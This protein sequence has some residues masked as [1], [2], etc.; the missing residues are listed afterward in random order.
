[1][2]ERR[3][4]WAS[5]FLMKLESPLHNIRAVI[6]VAGLSSVSSTEVIEA[7]NLYE[8]PDSSFKMNG[9]DKWLVDNGCENPLVLSPQQHLFGVYMHQRISRQVLFA[10]PQV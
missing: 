4:I 9:M 3:K 5:T 6:Q 1:M 7:T 10:H 8:Q 2:K